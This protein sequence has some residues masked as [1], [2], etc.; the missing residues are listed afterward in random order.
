M[1]PGTLL[2]IAFGALMVGAAWAIANFLRPYASPPR[3]QPLSAAE[4]AVDPDRWIALPGHRI[5][6]G[7]SGFYISLHTP[8]ADER[9]AEPYLYRLWTPEGPRPHFFAWQELP[10]DTAMIADDFA[11][12]CPYGSPGDRL[13]VRE[14]FRDARS[15]AAGRVLY[16]AD[17]DVA[18]GWKPSIHMP[19]S[20]SRITLEVTGVRVERLQA[21]SEADAL[22]EGV[23]FVADGCA[24][25]GVDGLPGSWC[26]CAVTA[27]A[28]LWESIN[29][30]GS[31]DANPW[32]WVIEFKRLPC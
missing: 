31:W 25:F 7:A 27:Y 21:I 15:H 23:S 9:L 6:L 8:R 19:R 12:P 14:A 24:R 13:W 10:H 32:V 26:D 2:A 29:G 16:R 20:A 22:A 4:R 11:M 18:C 1:T 17:G 5:E 30:A 28:A 3:R